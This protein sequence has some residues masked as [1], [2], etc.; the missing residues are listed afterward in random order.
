MSVHDDRGIP[1]FLVAILFFQFVFY[2]TIYLNVSV[3]RPIIGFVYLMF[4][5]GM[6]ILRALRLKVLDMTE[7]LVLSVALSI[8][9]L[10]LIGLL[11]N[12]AGQLAG[13]TNPLSLDSLVVGISVP[14]I[15]MSFMDPWHDDFGIDLKSSRTV[16]FIALSVFFLLLGVYGIIAVNTTGDSFLL[17]LLILVISILISLSL[18]SEKLVPSKF[19]P[20][21]LFVVCICVLFFICSQTAFITTHI[22]GTGDYWIEYYAFRLTS[23]QHYWNPAFAP[24]FAT[25]ALFPTY[26]MMSVT[27]LPVMFQSI[28]GL[29]SSIIFMLLYSFIIV[30]VALGVYKLYQTQTEKG[31]AF[32]AT[33]FFITISVG[34]GWG[35]AK[36]MVAQLFFV[37]LFFLLL[38]KG[39]SPSKKGILFV[40][41]S[42]GLVIS[43]YGLSYIFLLTLLF[44][45]LILALMNYRRIGKFSIY[46]TK[47]SLT[48][49]LIFSVIIFSWYIFVNQASAFNLLIE[50]ANTVT[51]NLGQF[52]NPSSRGTALAGL[53]IVQPTSIF[54]S[55]STVLFL[56]TEF[57]LVL[58]FIKL[59]TSKNK[60]S[61]F[62][63]EYKIFATLNMAII[64]I[65]IL[66]P[67][68]ADTLLM[69]R[70]YQTTLIILAPLA[71]LGGKTILERVLKAN[72][73]RFYIP[74][75]VLMVFVPLFM[76]QTGFIYEVAKVPS[77]SLPLSMYRFND[78]IL[79]GTIITSQEIAGATWLSSHA[80]SLVLYSDYFGARGPL[81][82]YGMF[83]SEPVFL[84]SNTTNNI[85]G[86][87]FVYLRY[88]NVVH[89]VMQSL[90]SF[91][92][93][94]ISPVLNN[95]NMIYSNGECEIYK[96][97]H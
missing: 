30:F 94:E 15:L 36:Q 37:L 81:L 24:S 3:I 76:F 12:Y 96:G 61:K 87:G 35:P 70:F 11:V 39:I 14:V 7:K 45:F 82:A 38:R 80:H 52:S 33:F 23:I 79:H 16:L 31:V 51:S 44:G 90:P 18:I 74:I 58:G 43:H 19:Y 59:I 95:Q 55:I 84:L 29:D 63:L 69:S 89:G 77:D 71:V 64:T 5:P 6:I 46:E 10:S 2:L 66:L 62:S 54:N 34:K 21:I 26:S 41:F 93:T 13:S 20:L 57:L 75:L 32:L 73:K 97:T 85:P 8:A 48:S 83:E 60:T 86:N 53:G 72:F 92:L 56:F 4:I 42:A 68:L 47:I 91:N 1:S 25:P 49:V 65:N 9:Y 88:T 67:T 78:V 50:T 22:Y 28:T 17:L 27:V 40:I